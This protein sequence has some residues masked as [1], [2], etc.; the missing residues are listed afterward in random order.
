MNTLVTLLYLALVPTGLALG[1]A[2]DHLAAGALAAVVA[3][4]VLLVRAA[5]GAVRSG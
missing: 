2:V 4:H 1:G 3:V 5:R